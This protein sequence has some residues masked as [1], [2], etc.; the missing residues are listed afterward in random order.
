MRLKLFL[1]SCII[2][3]SEEEIFHLKLNKLYVSQR[4]L[5][6]HDFE[7]ND[8]ASAFFKFYFYP[9]LHF[10]SQCCMTALKTGTLLGKR[11]LE[12]S[13]AADTTRKTRKPADVNREVKET[14]KRSCCCVLIKACQ[15]PFTNY[16]LKTKGTLNKLRLRTLRQKKV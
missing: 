11:G 9:T 8:L 14:M 3:S 6:D 10:K 5:T 13:R 4:A 16:P 15:N 2:H 7:K 12:W 1:F